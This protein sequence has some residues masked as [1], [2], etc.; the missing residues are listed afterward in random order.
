MAK[1]RA[2]YAAEFREQM[3]ELVASGRRPQEL[4]REFGCCA[5]TIHDWIKKAGRVI[6]LPR[7]TQIVQAS[8]QA[9]AVANATALSA[10]ERAE[11]ERLRKENRRLQI[12]RD[13]LA[14]ATA[15]FAETSVHTPNGSTRS[16]KLIRPRL[17]TGATRF[18]SYALCWAFRPVGI[19]TGAIDRLRHETALTHN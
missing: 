8:K 1:T 5:Q 17:I 14:K 4:A 12:E 6:D 15:W 9:R 3:V 7:G 10:D 19:T 2:P 11:L 13:I 16:G 18:D